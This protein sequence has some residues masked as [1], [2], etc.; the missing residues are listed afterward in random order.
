M[1]EA[2]N[3]ILGEIKLVGDLAGNG[4]AQLGSNP[5]LTHMVGL[6]PGQYNVANITV[7]IKGRITDIEGASSQQI[8]NLIPD[9]TTTVKGKVSIGDNIYTTP[10]ATSGYQIINF[11]GNLLTTT[12]LNYCP[13]AAYN[14]TLMVDGTTYVYAGIAD[15]LGPDIQSLINTINTFSPTFSVSLE[16]GNIKIQSDST[17]S[18]SSINIVTYGVFSCLDQFVELESPVIGQSSCEIYVKD[19]SLTDAGVVQIG[20]GIDVTDG[21]ISADLSSTPIST[22][23]T[24]GGVIV[25]V[26]GNIDVDIS[27]NIGVPIASDTVVGVISVGAGLTVDGSGVVSYST[28]ALPIASDTVLGC[29]KEGSGVSIDVNGVA[30]VDIGTLAT[31][32]ESSLGVVQIGDGIDVTDGIISVDLSEL[33]IPT[34]SDTVVGGIKI[35]NGLDI[36]GSA[37]CS[38]DPTELL[39]N[40]VNAGTVIVGPNIS[41]NTG[42]I[43]VADASTSTKGVVQIGTNTG[44]GVINGEVYG[45][46]ATTTNKGMVY[47]PTGTGL[48]ITAGAL[49]GVNATTS[50]KGVVQIG[51]NTGLSVSAG[52]LNGV[53]ATTST[54]GVVQIQSNTGLTVSGGLLSGTLSN[55]TTTLGVVKSANTDNIT[56]SSGLIDIGTNVPK[57]N[58]SNTWSNAQIMSLS[59]VAYTSPWTPNFNNSNVFSM[60]LSGA[61]PLVIENPTSITPGGVY[62]M[63]LTQDAT[64]GRMVTWNGSYFKFPSGTSTSLSV[65][66]NAVDIITMIC[67]SSTEIL[68]TISRGYGV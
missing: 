4:G 12:P 50:T 27:G 9:A 8:A 61:G 31:A 7:D 49:S 11:G 55:S 10:G 18:P 51:T 3:S 1:S 24:L 19:A 66:P 60:T 23:T 62:I 6:T 41:L 5:Q 14:L 32:T 30:T 43:S 58:V 46:L 48:S 2:T 13:E 21:I 22:T 59:T 26:S 40:G 17:G 35:G 15:N 54:K 45:E 34:A 64:G 33:S 42:T 52:V 63:L 56:I 47:V 68:V 20:D 28:S 39:A 67:K 53:N 65:E 36:D 29:V 25:P 57:L 16:N 38:V 44:L 37:V